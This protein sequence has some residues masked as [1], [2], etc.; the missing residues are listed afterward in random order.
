VDRLLLQRPV[1]TLDHAVGLRFGHEGK[2]LVD[3]PERDLVA[4]CAARH[5]ARCGAEQSG[6]RGKM[7][8]KPLANRADQRSN[9]I[10]I[11]R[12]SY[13]GQTSECSSKTTDCIIRTIA[14]KRL[15]AN[16]TK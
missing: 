1:E 11:L 9:A 2:A 15:S 7:G 14:Y 8:I 12:P 13:S 3:P 6:E 4:L 10:S 16:L 5:A